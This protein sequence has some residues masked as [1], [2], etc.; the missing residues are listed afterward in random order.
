MDT[1]RHDLRD[2]LEEVWPEAI[3]AT[4]TV[5]AEDQSCGVSRICDKCRSSP[6]HI[7]KLRY[8]GC[9]AAVHY[10]SK[11]GAKA[12]WPAHKLVCE[13]MRRARLSFTIVHVALRASMYVVRP[14]VDVCIRSFACVMTIK[15]HA[16][17]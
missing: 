3:Q 13:S 14:T 9:C 15:L 6:A 12:D 8:C 4:V 16:M 11:H 10:C 1:M 5:V 17:Q 2:V 7:D